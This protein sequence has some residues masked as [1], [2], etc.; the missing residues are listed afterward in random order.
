MH[1]HLPPIFRAKASYSRGEI[2]ILVDKNT[3]T[4]PRFVTRKRA[5][6]PLSE[7]FWFRTRPWSEGL[8]QSRREQ[9]KNS[10]HKHSKKQNE[11]ISDGNT[12]QLS[13]NSRHT[14]LR[15]AR[16]GVQNSSCAWGSQHRSRGG[17]V[18]RLVC[19]YVGLYVCM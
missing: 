6:R 1:L 5:H 15:T 19:M 2:L 14:K 11:L 10:S 4:R 13:S 18:C 16:G 3:G 17:F 12:L 8:A 9:N 7:G